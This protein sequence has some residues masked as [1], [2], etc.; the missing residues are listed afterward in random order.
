MLIVFVKAA[1]L[2]LPVHPSL[3]SFIRQQVKDGVR[4]VAEMERHCKSFVKN[5]LLAGKSLPSRFNRRY[6]PTKRD[7][8]NIMYAARLADMYSTVD[9]ENLLAKIEE[10]SSEQDNHFYFRPY[11]ESDSGT[12]GDAEDD[13]V[14]MQS[15][16]Q[17]GLLLVHQTSWQQRLLQRYGSMCLLDATY[18]TTRY[19]VPLFFLCVRTN[20]DYAVVATFVTQYE[21][22]SSIAEAMQVLADWNP[23]WTPQDFMV[24]FCEPEIMAMERVF[25]GNCSDNV[26][27]L[28][29]CIRPCTVLYLARFACRSTY[30]LRY[31]CLL[32]LFLTD[33]HV[34]VM[35]C[36]LL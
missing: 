2:K 30:I 8:I 18:K 24:D 5:Q 22:S 9:Q 13:D 17:S 11:A 16:G 20:V 15:G 36:N 14:L 26:C 27:M 6:F 28:L 33:V 12:S 1:G 10:W 21:D 3:N 31:S 29:D 35:L 7:I 32:S 23:H 19:A 34:I 25:A 4:S